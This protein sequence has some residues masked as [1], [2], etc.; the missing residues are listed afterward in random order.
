MDDI[1]PE[2]GQNKLIVVPKETNPI[3]E[4]IFS[5]MDL[6]VLDEII[7]DGIDDKGRP[8]ARCVKNITA[9]ISDFIGM[10]INEDSTLKRYDIETAIKL[11]SVLMINIVQKVLF[12][13]IISRDSEVALKEFVK[14][15]KEGSKIASSIPR[16]DISPRYSTEPEIV[17]VPY[18]SEEECP[19]KIAEDCEGEV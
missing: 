14:Y 7:N 9:Y 15:A 3:I 5:K 17:D 12:V 13:H 1:N 10:I 8:T 2:G 16:Q 18:K 6:E 11:E 4:Q 19:V